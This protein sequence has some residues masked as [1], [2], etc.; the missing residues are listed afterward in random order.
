MNSQLVNQLIAAMKKV[1]PTREE[2][3]TKD[4]L[5]AFATKDDLS[6][7]ATKDDLK[8]LKNY[9]DKKISHLPTKE[10]FFDRMDKLSGQLKKID[11]EQVLQ[12]GRLS[13]QYDTLENHEERIGILEKIH[14]MPSST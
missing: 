12:S 1:F 11:E 13:E 3:A 10:E 4:D 6:A 7:F 5:S 2:V 14:K 8:E 9:I